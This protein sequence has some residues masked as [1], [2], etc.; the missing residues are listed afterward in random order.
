M[1]KAPNT[2]KNTP[3]A[4][5]KAFETDANKLEHKR[6]EKARKLAERIA[7][8]QSKHAAD[9]AGLTADIDA[10]RQHLSDYATVNRD[11]LTDN[12]KKK[13]LTIGACTLKWRKKAISVEIT[14]EVANI[15]AALKK[16][17]LGR[18]VR[19][20]EEIDKTAIKAESERLSKK[21]IDGIRIVEGGE[22]LAIDTGAK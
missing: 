21:P 9:A 13:T 14:G 12:G 11:S 7:D 19:V 6:A 5:L 17:R 20:K 3:Y 8:L 10:I 15:I 4:S 1:T 2:P 16:R 22:V 18:C